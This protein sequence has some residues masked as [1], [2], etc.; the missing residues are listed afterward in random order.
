M[1]GLSAPWSGGGWKRHGIS[2]LVSWAVLMFMAALLYVR[3]PGVALGP[4]GP[5]LSFREIAPQ[6]FGDRQNSKAWSMI[7]WKGKLYVGTART[8]Q[9]LEYAG[10]EDVVGDPFQYPPDDPDMEC[11][12]DPQDL[13]LNAEIWRYT[14]ETDTWERV[15][16]SPDIPIPDHPDKLTARDAG[17]RNIIAFTDPDGTEALYA[18]GITSESINPG[19]PPPRILRS[20][21]GEHWEAVPQ[22]PGTV[23]GDLGRGQA[24]FRAM[25][26]YKDRL[27]VTN[28]ALR[29]GGTLM[30]AENP[31]GGND[32]FQWINPELR[33]YEMAVYNGYLY[34]GQLATSDDPRAG[35]A[36]S[37]TD[38]EG[39]P[40][41]TFTT[42]VGEGGY[43]KPIPSNA[44]VSMFVYKG[45]LYVGTDKPAEM[46]R[47]NPDD[48]WD[49]VVGAPRDTP[50]GR[51]EPL[52]GMSFGFDWLL[53]E[54]IW[55]MG[56]YGGKMYV[57]TNDATGFL[58]E[59]RFAHPFLE[60]MGYDLFVTSDGVEY[61]MLTRTGFYNEGLCD[62]QFGIGIR[63]FASSPYGLFFGTS[64]PF[65][66]LRIYLGE[67]K[68]EY[69]VYLPLI[70]KA[71]S[72]LLGRV[73]VPLQAGALGGRPA[74]GL[75][76]PEHLGLESQ[77]GIAILSWEPVSEAVRYH[78]FRSDFVP[79]W[80]LGVRDAEP[81]LRVPQ[82]FKE[83]AVVEHLLFVDTTT[84]AG[85][86]YHYYVRAEG[87]SGFL[88]PPSN[89][90]RAPSLNTPV[91]VAGLRQIVAGWMKRDRRDAS[92]GEAEIT[93]LLDDVQ[94]HI[95]AGDLQ[96]ASARLERLRARARA[97]RVPQLSWWRAEDLGWLLGKLI[98]RI[99]LAQ[100]GLLA[101]EE[102]Q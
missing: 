11:T 46:I 27:F 98:R 18:G 12:E 63:V 19:M 40:P 25:A 57:G 45:R 87:P 72:L 94:E 99:R 77:G 48:T 84:Q 13:P 91:T 90:A 51:K 28:G 82:P 23:L 75:S 85:R 43:Y 65:Y 33:V 8:H 31:A 47:I 21:D 32:N 62:D 17:F 79:A 55:R 3:L 60:G 35:Y 50:E 95:R 54:H 58:K 86:V 4:S 34:I 24:N 59:Y 30:M 22:D 26:I 61:T 70:Q 2:L 81:E 49:L 52:S 97:G 14:P 74:L 64:D 42:V 76:A 41:Y 53:N 44:V 66:G 100:A 5:D 39:S 15:F 69:R 29:G 1:G 78:I 6:G 56:E 37:R 92:R 36:V 67:P 88:S 9:C 101:P 83:I 80:E 93:L 71:T 16:R 102:L 89:L 68:P 38:A 7:W 73:P 10:L 96:G 20:T